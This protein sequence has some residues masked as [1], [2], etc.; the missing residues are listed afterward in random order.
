[1]LITLPDDGDVN[2]NRDDDI[3]IVFS[4]AVA[5]PTINDNSV[6]VR[7]G[8]FEVPGSLAVVGDTVVFTADDI[9]DES[10][11]YTGTISTAVTDLAGNAL[12]TAFVWSFTTGVLPDVLA[13]RVLRTVPDSGDVD[14]EL[15]TNVVITFSEPMRGFVLNPT[16]VRLTK[17]LVVVAAA[18]TSVGAVATLSPD[19]ELEEATLYT[20]TVTTAAADLAGN[21]LAVPFTSSFTTGSTPRVSLTAPDNLESEVPIARNIVA[22]FSE[23]VDPLSFDATAFVVSDGAVT[24]DGEVI[25]IGNVATFNPT[26]ML[27]P[28]T[29]Y[30]ATIGTAVT[31]VDGHAMLAPFVW[32]FTAD[33]CGQQPIN[34]RSASTTAVLAGSTITN[35]GATTI[36]GDIATSPGTAITGF[37]PGSV[38]GSIHAG[39]AFAATAAADVNVAFTEA[40]GRALCPVTVAGNLGG[41]T[42]TPGLYTS[43]SSLEVSSGNLVLDAGGD[44]DAVFVFQMASTLTVTSGRRVVLAGGAQAT[45][46]YW[47]VGTAATLGTTSSWQG[48]VLAADAITLEAGATITGRAL[49]GSAVVLDSNVIN[50]P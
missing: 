37:P 12:A 20:L 46:V 38:V 36:V 7:D 41:S 28:G 32:T 11:V 44:S 50:A 8:I 15:D 43:T 9:L 23:D 27:V 19:A 13:P 6:V 39:D 42:R 48:T 31:D 16:T 18:V 29:T 17:G 5:V 40:A 4:E 22:T 35:T 26:D 2:V 25:V 33:V 30:T 24:V 47:Q 3:T 10:T 49:A 14:V 45:N 34:L 21:A 1:V